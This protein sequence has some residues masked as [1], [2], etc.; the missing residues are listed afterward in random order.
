[1]S[2]RRCP[3]GDVLQAKKDVQVPQEEDPDDLH[4]TNQQQTTKLG[5]T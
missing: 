4:P 1:M 2:C 5:S 3:V